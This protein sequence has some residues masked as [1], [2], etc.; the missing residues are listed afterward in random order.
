PLGTATEQYNA[1]CDGAGAFLPW[2]LA[3]TARESA[4]GAGPHFSP[5]GAMPFR[6]A[7]CC[8]PAQ[9]RKG[10]VEALG[11]LGAAGS[12]VVSSHGSLAAVASTAFAGGADRT[13]IAG[14]GRLRADGHPVHGEL[15]RD[16]GYDD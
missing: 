4:R 14:A 15:R 13:V 2:H 9:Y 16:R 7:W 10:A 11:P 8:G 6:G 5:R 1:R 3:G 12:R